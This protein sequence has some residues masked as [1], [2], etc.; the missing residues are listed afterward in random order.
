MGADLAPPPGVR[1]R[2]D[3]VGADPARRKR[4]ARLDAG[5]AEP[6]PLSRRI[7]LGPQ[8][9]IELA[10]LG[11]ERFH[12]LARVETCGWDGGNGRTCERGQEVSSERELSPP[13]L[14]AR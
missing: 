11:V 5:V 10:G 3:L 9:D 4:A 13:Q 1:R 6:R 12:G 8:P 7:R 2:L 14:W